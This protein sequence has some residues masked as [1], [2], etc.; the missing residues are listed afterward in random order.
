MEDDGEFVYCL[1]RRDPNVFCN[2]YNLQ[3]VSAHKARN[4][5][6]FWIVTASFVTK[7]IYNERKSS[8]AID[9]AVGVR[10]RKRLITQ[11]HGSE[12]NTGFL[13]FLKIVHI[14]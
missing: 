14:F 4:C 11:I 3:V 1:P 9:E 6:E 8:L 2:P 5:K 12:T 7:V 13:H 10:E